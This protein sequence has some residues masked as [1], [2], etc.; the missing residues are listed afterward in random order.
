MKENIYSTL[1]KQLEETEKLGYN[2]ESAWISY[3]LL[4]DRLLSI[5]RSTGGDHLPN[6]NEIRMMGPK[7]GH[8]KTRMTT[9]EILREHLE[10]ANLI[11]R[12][13]DWKD[14]RNVLM[15]SMADGSMSILQIENDIAI[16]AKDGT[17]LVR[18]FAS[19]ARRIKKHNK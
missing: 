9:N 15:H 2:F 18:D 16:L 8:I 7:I 6:G 3:V 1:I 10:V 4:E 5:L 12:I 14:K 11:P 19:A 13:E 17:T